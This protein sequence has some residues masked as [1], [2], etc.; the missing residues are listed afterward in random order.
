[1]IGSQI[2][3]KPGWHVVYNFSQNP[4]SLFC[5][6][7]LMMTKP[8]WVVVYNVSQKLVNLLYST[9]IIM[10]EPGGVGCLGTYSRSHVTA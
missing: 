6:M 2:M 8:I 1:M 5:T 9:W 4:A 7:W 10:A 3:T